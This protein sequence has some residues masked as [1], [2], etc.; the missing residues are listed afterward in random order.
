MV[1]SAF[2]PELPLPSCPGWAVLFCRRWECNMRRLDGG[3]KINLVGKRGAFE[4][5]A[6]KLQTPPPCARS[7]EEGGRGVRMGEGRSAS[8]SV[9]VYE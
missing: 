8:S 3:S 1:R 6:L 9:V 5:G 2:N 7:G 4:N